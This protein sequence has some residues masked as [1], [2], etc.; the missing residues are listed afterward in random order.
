[1]RRLA[2]AVKR[3]GHQRWFA[4]A[5]ARVLPSLDRA[6]HRL[7]GGRWLVTSAA[8]PT[9]LLRCGISAK[10]IPLL[11]VAHDGGYLVAATNWGRPEHPRWSTRL[12]EVG[13]AT[14]EVAREVSPVRAE[15]LTETEV[16]V[17]WPLLVEVWPAFDTYR[18]RAR[19]EI[20][21]FRLRPD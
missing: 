13:A 20:R 15:R 7:S 4:A 21:V 16:G 1:M 17:V 12:L 14:V 2:S 10:P 3:L 18:A 9:L 5:G 6:V 11:Y 8:F 19:R